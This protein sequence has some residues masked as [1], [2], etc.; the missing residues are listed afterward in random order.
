MVE[1]KVIKNMVAIVKK[2][3]MMGLERQLDR[4]PI[5]FSKRRKKKWNLQKSFQEQTKG[6]GLNAKTIP[7]PTPNQREFQRRKTWKRKR[8]EAENRPVATE[9]LLG[10]VAGEQLEDGVDIDDGVVGLERVRDHEPA[11]RRL[12]QVPNGKGERAPIVERESLVLV[13]A[14]IRIAAVPLHFFNPLMELSSDEQALMIIL[15]EPQSERKNLFVAVRAPVET[16]QG[17]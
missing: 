3:N 1:S 8:R 5:R 6:L 4:I 15:D 12:E 13:T 9:N 16:K 14:Q 17:E 7:I 11:R 10:A 2:M